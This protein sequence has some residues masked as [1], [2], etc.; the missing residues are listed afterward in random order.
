MIFR[1]RMI[2]LASGPS[3]SRARRSPRVP[4]D[5]AV[6]LAVAGLRLTLGPRLR[7]LLPRPRLLGSVLTKVSNRGQYIVLNPIVGGLGLG[8]ASR[9]ASTTEIDGQDAESSFCQYLRLLLPTLLIEPPSM[10][11]HDDAL[12][13]SIHIG[14]DKPPSWVGKETCS[15]AAANPANRRNAM[16][17]LLKIG[18]PRFLRIS[19]N[20]AV[21]PASLEKCG[22]T[23]VFLVGPVP[24][25]TRGSCPASFL[26]KSIRQ[27]NENGHR[28][29]NCPYGW[30]ISAESPNRR[31]DTLLERVRN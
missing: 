8:A 9:L 24:R 7:S 12:R 10:S 16:S 19:S 13:S 11:Q 22:K 20:S 28:K 30:I 31:A 15:C 14:V 2:V 27:T 29:A 1:L 23:K 5:E 17:A 21:L 3:F 25:A 26:S 18:T 6:Y 4:A